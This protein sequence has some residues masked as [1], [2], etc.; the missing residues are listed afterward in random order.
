MCFE[1]CKGASRHACVL[2][3]FLISTYINTDLN[4]HRGMQVLLIGRVLGGVAYSLLYS[5]FEV[6]PS[7]SASVVSTDIPLKGCHPSAML[8]W[9]TRVYSIVFRAAVAL[10]ATSTLR[11]LSQPRHTGVHQ[12][13]TA[14]LS[15]TSS[16]TCLGGVDILDSGYKSVT[17]HEFCLRYSTLP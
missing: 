16:H 6:R 7:C 9:M 5:S 12:I 4:L 3:G 8:K 17:T 2:R 13:L 10:M 14:A 11:R 15:S 1:A